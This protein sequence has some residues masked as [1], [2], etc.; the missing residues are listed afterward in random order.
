MIDT[1]TLIPRIKNAISAESA[2]LQQIKVEKEEVMKALY[3]ARFVDACDIN[4]IEGK[5]ATKIDNTAHDIE[6]ME[7]HLRELTGG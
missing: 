2:T 5:F 3:H 4:R 1:A 6:G 7:Q